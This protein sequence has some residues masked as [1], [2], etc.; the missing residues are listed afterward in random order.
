MWS[1]IWTFW[2]EFANYTWKVSHSDFV[3]FLAASTCAH[4]LSRPWS[5]Y[6]YHDIS[7]ISFC[8]KN[9]LFSVWLTDYSNKYYGCM[10]PGI[11]ACCLRSLW[12]QLPYLVVMVANM[13]VVP[14]VLALWLRT[15]EAM[16][17]VD[18]AVCNVPSCC[19]WDDNGIKKKAFCDPET[20]L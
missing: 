11:C 18:Y 4:Q 8:V 16:W 13:L 20:E 10:W 17:D 12:V 2:R 5:S 14:R 15:T 6:R 7:A 1:V 19:H 3:E 9:L